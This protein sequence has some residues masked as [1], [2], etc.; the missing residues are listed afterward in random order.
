MAA[1]VVDETVNA[2]ARFEHGVD[3]RS[4]SLLVSDIAG[5]NGGRSAVFADLGL[6]NSQL[7]RAAADKRDMGAE[8]TQFVRGATTDAAAASGD[9]HGL[10]FE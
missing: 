4:D 5:M 9:D 6:D 10:A 2:S 1:S 3:R 8:R 7:I